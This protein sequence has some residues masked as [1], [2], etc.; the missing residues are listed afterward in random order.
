[1]NQQCQ[2]T[3]LIHDLAIWIYMYNHTSWFRV[4]CYSQCNISSGAEL[5][6]CS[7]RVKSLFVL[8][9]CDGAHGDRHGSNAL[10][11]MH[12]CKQYKCLPYVLHVC[13]PCHYIPFLLIRSFII[14]T[15]VIVA[16]LSTTITPLQ[17]KYIYT[18]RFSVKITTPYNVLCYKCSVYLSA[19]DFNIV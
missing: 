15:F 12:L 5:V 7:E 14:Q 4:N 2:W 10:P 18:H 17:F 11:R 19:F 13:Y 8:C 9:V 6:W 1:M 16:L 3:K